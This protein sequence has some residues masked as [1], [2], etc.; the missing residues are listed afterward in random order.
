VFVKIRSNTG[1]SVISGEHW[2]RLSP[3]NYRWLCGRSGPASVIMISQHA[4]TAM[5]LSY[6]SIHSFLWFSIYL[7]Y[8]II[9]DTKMPN[10]GSCVLHVPELKKGIKIKKCSCVSTHLRITK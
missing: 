2:W 8:D 6:L 5:C 1:H 10:Y 7:H 4:S 3:L 9:N